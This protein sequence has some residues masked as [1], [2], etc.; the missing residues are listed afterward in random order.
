MPPPPALF[1][2]HL[3]RNLAVLGV[4]LAALA[5]TAALAEGPPAPAVIVER[6]G[7]QRIT[8]RLEALGTLKANETVRVTATVSERVSRVFFEDG[9]QVRA[10]DILAV[11]DNAEQAALLAEA[12]SLAEEAERQYRRIAQLVEAGN[13]SESLADERRREWRAA[14]ARRDAASARL[15]HHTIV[16]PFSGRVGLRNIS[17]GALV[18][19]GDLITTLVDDSQLKLDFTMPA[20]YLPTVR[21]GT[22]IEAVT[23]VFP[24]RVF[25]GKVASVDSGVDPVTRSITVRAILPN[26]TGDLMPG[27]LMNLDL[28]HGARDAL[29]ISESAVVPRGDQAFV[30]VVSTDNEPYLAVE[31]P[32]VLGMRMPGQVE[33]VSGLDAGETIITHGAMKVRPGSPVR[34]HAEDDGTRPIAELIAPEPAAEPG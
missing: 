1:S 16:A 28:L 10:G 11:L 4:L 32:V 24:D 18:S 23:P 15:R 25:T 9:Q 13:A 8:D 30:L 29:V 26:E 6:V 7:H 31:R 22:I 12:E 34:I 21:P 17:P 20:L 27:M 2:L 19:P 3:R 33:V 5:A 14:A